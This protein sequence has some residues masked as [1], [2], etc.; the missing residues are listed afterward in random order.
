M[1]IDG[2]TI[3]VTGATGFLGRHLCRELVNHG[4]N[5]LALDNFSIGSQEALE[6]IPGHLSVVQADIREPG[7]I[8]ETLSQAD[9]VYHLAA[10]ANPRTCT[11]DFGLAF[12]VNVRGT[13]HVLEASQHVERFVCL[14]SI[15]VY[16]EP[17]Y[18]P[19]DERHPLDGRDPYAASKIICEELVKIANFI[20][21]TPFT[22][23]RNSN[24]YG[25]HQS[26]AYLT[27]TLIQQAL[28]NGVIEIWDPRVI[29]DFLYVQDTVEALIGMVETEAAAGEIINLGGGL[30]VSAG[31][32]AD[33]ICK[34][35]GASWVDVK[36]PA[37]V[38]SKLIADTSKLQ[39]LT[40]WHQRVSLEDGVARTVEHFKSLVPGALR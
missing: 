12:D 18:L 38:S 23:V 10:I 9:M 26:N 31:E 1:K 13:A 32:M 37:A 36:K 39:A 16:G 17:R 34:Q 28:D 3:C 22:I 8:V 24:S 27:P 29:R 25:P 21:K 11:S 35:L 4:A 6:E 30:G 20:H 14:S 33:L 19:I 2:K 5:V 15:M 40:G 7:T